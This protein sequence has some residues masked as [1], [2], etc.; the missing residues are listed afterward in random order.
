MFSCIYFILKDKFIYR[1]VGLFLVTIFIQNC[2][3]PE[4]N[5]SV[6]ESAYENTLTNQTVGDG[7]YGAIDDYFYDLSII[8]WLRSN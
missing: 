5:E 4:D 6:K 1:I 7:S 2:A 8:Q 3:E